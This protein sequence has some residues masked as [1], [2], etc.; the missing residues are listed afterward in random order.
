LR[1]ASEEQGPADRWRTVRNPVIGDEVTFVHTARETGGE[2]TLARVL[3]KPGGGNPLHYHLTYAEDFEVLDGRLTIQ[4]DGE[5]LMLGPGETAHAPIG[6]RHRFANDTDRPVTFLTTIRPARRFEEQIRIAYGLARDGKTI[7]GGVPRNPLQLALLFE[8]SETYLPALP[9]ALQQGIF[10]P[11][12]RL[13]HW[14]KSE[15]S[16]EKYLIEP[17]TLDR[18]G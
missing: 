9:L 16:F 15:R 18:G 10:G 8:I 1:P 3:L 7:G 13:A 17:D 14:L 11:L 2:H 6:S 5:R 12:A 4:R